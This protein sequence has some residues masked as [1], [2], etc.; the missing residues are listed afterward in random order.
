MRKV[1]LL[2]GALAS[3]ALAATAIASIHVAVVNPTFTTPTAGIAPGTPAV[4]APDCS[5]PQPGWSASDHWTTYANDIHASI[6]SWL[7]LAPDGTPANL[8]AVGGGQSGLVQVLAPQFKET[9][10]NRVSAMVYVLG[11]QA[12]LQIGDGGSGGGAVAVSSTERTWEMISACGRS[13]MRNNEIVVY[14]VGPAVFYVS[15]VKVAF[16]P[17]CP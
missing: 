2:A 7:T 4:T 17:T 14:G 11:G 3:G 8:V 16:D 9:D 12:S 10:V 1:S 5:V 15:S 6:A 13:D